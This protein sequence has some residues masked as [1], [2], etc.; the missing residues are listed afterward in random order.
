VLCQ[1]TSM[2]WANKDAKFPSSEDGSQIFEAVGLLISIEEVS[3]ET[4]AQY[5]AALLN[6]LCHQI[7]SLVMDAKAQGLEESSPK[8]ISLQQIIVALNMVSK[9]FNERLVMGNR[10]AI[11]VMFKKTLDVVLQVIVSFPNVKPCDLR[12]YPFC[13]G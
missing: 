11:G 8:A 4:Q 2:D 9:G 1:F 10:P 3:P 6:P 12:S 7:E 5:L 13:I